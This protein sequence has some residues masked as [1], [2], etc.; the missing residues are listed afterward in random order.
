MKRLLGIIDDESFPPRIARAGQ[1]EEFVQVLRHKN[2][3][4]IDPDGLVARLFSPYIRQC[5]VLELFC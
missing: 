3:V 5:A 1:F 2:R 4:L